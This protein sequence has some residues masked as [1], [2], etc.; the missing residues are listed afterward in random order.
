MKIHPL[1][2][3]TYNL[4][5]ILDPITATAT[6][7]THQSPVQAKVDAIY[8]PHSHTPTSFGMH[9]SISVTSRRRCPPL[10]KALMH[11]AE[12]TRMRHS[13]CSLTFIQNRLIIMPFPS[14]MCLYIVSSTSHSCP[15]NQ[16]RA[17]SVSYR[18]FIK[19][20]RCILLLFWTIFSLLTYVVCSVIGFT[21][22][23]PSNILLLPEPVLGKYKRYRH[24][25]GKMTD[26]KYQG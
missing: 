1:L 7:T 10:E 18:F 11:Y 23:I 9:A 8:P 6:A 21:A 4:F 22:Q 3:T 13:F 5:I 2:H 16:Y 24:D 17:R 26:S 20:A 12:I 19:I 25:R 14:L 15:S